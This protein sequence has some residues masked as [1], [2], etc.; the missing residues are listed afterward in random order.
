MMGGGV[1][2]GRCVERSSPV[3]VLDVEEEMLFEEVKWTDT[4]GR[5]RHSWR[6]ES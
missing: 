2:C 1:V 3:V 6:A 5:S 4:R